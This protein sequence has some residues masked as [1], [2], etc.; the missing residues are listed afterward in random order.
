MK[1]AEIFAAAQAIWARAAER[2]PSIGNLPPMDYSLRGATAGQCRCRGWTTGR[3]GYRRNVKVVALRWNVALARQEGER[4]RNTI[5]HEIAH[6]VCALT[7]GNLTHNAEWQRVCR[8]LGG[9]GERCH[10]YDT[11]QVRVRPRQ[12][13][14]AVVCSN[15]HTLKAGPIQAKRMA[16]GALYR[17]K[18]GSLVRPVEASE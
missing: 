10:T 9:T 2:Y 7:T 8:A 15:G 13:R 16:E 12:P 4:Y 5:A 1:H 3:R 18:C 6:A 17:C 11:E 14:V